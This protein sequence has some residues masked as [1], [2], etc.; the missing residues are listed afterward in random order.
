M[1]VGEGSRGGG[2]KKAYFSKIKPFFA[3]F[4]KWGG[5]FLGPGGTFWGGG[6]KGVDENLHQL[7]GAV[8]PPFWGSGGPI[9]GSPGGS[10]G[11]KQGWNAATCIDIIYLES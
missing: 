4:E 1:D 11:A 6:K 10:C 2:T 7:W 8:F 3:V 9:L 5:P